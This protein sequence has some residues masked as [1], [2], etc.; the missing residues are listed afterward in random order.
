MNGLSSNESLPLSNGWP[1]P[2]SKEK[3]KP[4]P[5]ALPLTP[6]T[7]GKGSG[8]VKTSRGKHRNRRS[9]ILRRLDVDEVQLAL[10]PQIAPLLRL[11]GI[12]PERLVEVLRCDSN[13]ESQNF[14]QAWD[15]QTP[16]ARHLVGIEAIGA[17]VGLLPRRLWELFA[18]AALIQANE[19][20][21]VMIAL[22]LPEVIRTTIK[23][24]KKA[25]GLADR[26]HLLKAARVLPTPK[27]SVTNIL[28]PGAKEP[29][30]S[31]EDDTKGDL[32]SSDAF[33]LSAAKIMNPQKALPVAQVIEE[34]EEVL[35]AE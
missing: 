26:E 9:E 22:S 14:I 27:G 5:S 19:S 29:E 16:A 32:E 18:G 15:K 10:H 12:R 1:L 17:S 34:G 6:K 30:E 28:V 20:V 21:T 2:R 31:T 4:R 13:P 11:N 25:K 3:E 7:K 33:V 24:A 8:S 35:D 23:G